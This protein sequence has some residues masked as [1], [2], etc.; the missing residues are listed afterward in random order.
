MK[1]GFNLYARIEELGYKEISS[2]KSNDTIQEFIEIFEL[3]LLKNRKDGLK[4]CSLLAFLIY[5]VI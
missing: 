1:T 2:R 5:F 3:E 4:V